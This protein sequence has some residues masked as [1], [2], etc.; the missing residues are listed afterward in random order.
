MEGHY[1]Q[2]L[3]PRVKEIKVVNPAIQEI[4]VLKKQMELRELR[5]INLKELKVREL[6]VIPVNRES[7]QPIKVQSLI[8]TLNLLYIK[9]WQMQ[10]GLSGILKRSLVVQSF[11]EN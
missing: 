2:H 1:P 8:R 7:R 11:C 9:N 3:N 4:R 6:R 5:E 10:K